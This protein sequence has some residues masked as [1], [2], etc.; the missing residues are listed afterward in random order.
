MG[1]Y[2]VALADAGTTSDFGSEIN[3]ALTTSVNP[4]SLATQF[5][6]IIPWV[7][8]MVVVAFVIYEVRKLVKGAGKGKV[9]L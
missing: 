3:T 6:Q 5:V 9:R 2:L 7:G 8:L 1:N 4:N